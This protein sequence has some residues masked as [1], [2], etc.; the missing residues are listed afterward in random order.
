[1]GWQPEDLS[2]QIDGAT[3]DF[4]TTF[5][6]VGGRLVVFQDGKRFDGF[7]EPDLQTIRITPA[8]SSGSVFVI[9][10]TDQIVDGRIQGFIDDPESPPVTL[11]V[12]LEDILESL[13]Q[14]LDVLEAVGVSLGVGGTGWLNVRDV[15]PT[16]TGAVGNRIWQTPEQ[17]VLLSAQT[18][19]TDLDVSIQASGPR[20]LI[21]DVGHDLTQVAGESHYEGVF[22]ITIPGSGDIVAS[23]VT[24]EGVEGALHSVTM[25]VQ[26]AP[27]VLTCLFTG[28]YPGAQTEL[29]AGDTFQIT[30]TTDA[31]AV[32]IDIQDFGAFD[33]SLEVIVEGTS[34]TVTGTI[35]DRGTSVQDL[36]ARVRAQDSIGAVGATFDT[37]S[38]GTVDGVN[39][40]KLNNLF[41][42][43]TIG[44]STYPGIQAALKGSE[45]ATVVM[46][47]ADLDTIA[48]DSPNGDLSVTNP[49]TDETPKTV[50]RIAGSYNVSTNNF[51]ATAN[52]AANDATTVSQVVVRI[53]NVAATFGVAEPAARLRSGGNDG[54]SIQS[55]SITITADQE[56]LQAPVLD[57]DAGGGTL[58]GAWV[59]GPE[60]WTRTL[61]VH[62]DDVKATYT[63]Q[64][65]SITNL[66]GLVTNAITGDVQYVLGGFVARNVTFP[67]FSQNGTINVEV[68]DYSKLTAGIFTSTN[69]PST[70]NPVQGDTSNLV[71]TY[72]VLVLGV[73]PSTVFWNDLAAASANSGGTAQ[74]LAIEEV[75]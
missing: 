35:A 4:T 40:V 64:N 52:R 24:P 65:P 44:A 2:A 37:D 29:K 58:I 36:P 38:A 16:T 27:E 67:A 6:R 20:V 74:L 48:F 53:A 69:Q 12:S 31:P 23:L 17:D 25:L 10:W 32:A 43:A 9:Y 71:D 46:T 54:T 63:W 14:R 55:H 30:G 66:A 45:T 1:M 34:F 21:N 61:Q 8:P 60:V 49:T 47:T 50:Q 18:D 22:S 26:A 59:G 42:T 56:L 5:L 70:R 3:T 41:P 28:G 39:R 15:T 72:T 75:A 68:V 13:D 57:A 19:V 11:P 7:A 73:N 33:A 62:D 51:R